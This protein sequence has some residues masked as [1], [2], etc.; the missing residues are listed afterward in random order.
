MNKDNSKLIGHDFL[1]KIG[2]KRLRPGGKKGTNFLISSIMKNIPNYKDIKILEVSCNIGTTAI[3]LAKKLGCK[4]IGIDIDKKAIEQAKENIKKNNL[5]NQIEV[6]VMN[7]SNLEFNDMQFDVIINEAMLT[8]YKNKQVFLEQYYKYLKDGGF[9]LT[10]DICFK[11][12][13]QSDVE[14]EL[15]DVINIRPY[16]LTIE[17][18]KNLLLENNFIPIDYMV[19]KMRLVSPSAL[20]IDEGIFGTIKIFM[21]AVK[22]ENREKFKQM[23]NYFNQNKDNLSFI[24]I[25]SKKDSLKKIN[26][27]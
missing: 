11:N 25:I 14:N 10:H 9:L 6:Y 1:R 3:E 17:N 13:V 27:V 8:M 4:I 15:K 7:A 23:F 2:K 19:G 16:P 26:D 22:K 20:V 18:W 24:A 12:K 21:N 5:E